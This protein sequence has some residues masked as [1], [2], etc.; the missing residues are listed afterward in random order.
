MG[1][2]VDQEMA[3]SRRGPDLETEVAR[4]AHNTKWDKIFSILDLCGYYK[5]F[6]RIVAIY[7][8]YVQ[9][10]VSYNNK[11][12]LWSATVRGYAEVV[13]NLFKLRS[14]SPPAA[15]SNPN[16]MTEILLNNMLQEED[17]TRQR[18]LLDNEIFTKLR[19]MATAS[20]CKDSV[21]DLL[22]DV[23][24]LGC[25]IGSCLS[26][27]AQTPQ[28]KVNHHT[29]PSGKMVIKAFIANDFIFY[30]K[31]KWVVKDLNNDSLQRARF[32]KITWHIQ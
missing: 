30:N 1:H 23:V 9:C 7:I 12:V 5:G 10:G 11:Q 8:K 3:Q 2:R 21:S 14:F 29:H 20:K 16:N 28:D 27:Y 32:V 19:Q 6:I 18:A 31:K 26:I 22:F 4:Q 17:V 24:A 13:H 25:Y 15:L